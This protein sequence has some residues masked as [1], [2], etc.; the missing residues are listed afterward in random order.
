M[1]VQE[2][3]WERRTIAC[4]HFAEKM[5]RKMQADEKLVNRKFAFNCIVNDAEMYLRM[6][7]QPH[8]VTLMTCS[9]GAAVVY[10]LYPLSAKNLKG[11]KRA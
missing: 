5:A 6:G 3:N 11:R 7:Y 8:E 4:R 1:K 2:Y 9:D 10:R